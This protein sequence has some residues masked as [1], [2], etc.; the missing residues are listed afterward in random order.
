VGSQDASAANF[1]ILV[2]YVLPGFTA[3]QGLPFLANVQGA[4]G[5]AGAGASATLPSFLSG[6]VEAIAA[7][8][9]VSTVRWF[10]ID[11]LHHCTGLRPPP[12]DFAKLEK[13]VAA[14]QLLLDSHYRYYKFYA[15][16]VVALSCAYA[17][18]S[19]ALGWYGLVYLLL[20]A[21]FLLASRDALRKYYERA[22]HLLGA[23]SGSV[24]T[25][26]AF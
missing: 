4:W 11:R 5:T 20:V 2:C 10:V 18:R 24:L 8:L 25:V 7:G 12:W 1:G 3:V 23:K 15:N 19:Y 17:T 9:T 13:S 16:M 26:V 21:L 6:T 14:F 22:G